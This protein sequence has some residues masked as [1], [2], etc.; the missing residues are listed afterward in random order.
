MAHTPVLLKEVLEYLDPKPGQFIIDGTVNRGGH[1]TAILKKMMPSGKYLAVDLDE[2]ILENTKSE[3]NSKFQIPNSTFEIVWQN[4]N[5][6]NIPEILKRKEM[7]KAD[8]LLVDLGF[9]SAQIENSNRGFS[10]QKNEPLDM[11][12][13]I[14]QKLMA[15]DVVNKYS[16]KELADIIW[17]FGEERFSRRIAKKIIEERAKEPIVNTFQLVEVIKMAVPRSYEKGRIHPAT[18][19]FQALRIFV[20]DELGNLEKLLKNLDF[21]LNR[22]GRAV[23]ISFHSL[24]DRIV[25]NYFKEMKQSKKVE[26][27]T[28][29]PITATEEEI[30]LNPRSRSAKL[31]AI[32][33]I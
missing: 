10:F 31:R 29:K 19:T 23:I 15:H 21:I 5:Y 1:T 2:N 13:D 8:G 12:Y 25:K 9:S 14:V 30:R 33:I 17:K 20:N 4:D 7:G 11:R 24:E 26:L 3:I 28:K 16:E 18:R 27:L 32:K 22:D 6:A